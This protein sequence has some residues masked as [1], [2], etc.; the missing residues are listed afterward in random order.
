M[1]LAGRLEEIELAEL[2]HFLAL[3]LVALPGCRK[4]QTPP[5]PIQLV[6]DLRSPDSEKSGHARLLLITLGEPAVPAVTGLL[7][8]GTPAERIV[9]A[10]ILWGM[11]PRGQVAVPDLVVTLD[12]PDPSLRGASAMALENMGSAAEAAVPA[13]AKALSDREPT[14]R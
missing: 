11:G 1:S 10:N 5:D 12:D 7:R 9:A 13:L 6:A 14:V 4:K 3:L 2:L 8:S